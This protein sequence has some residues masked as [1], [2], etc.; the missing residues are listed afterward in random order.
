MARPRLLVM[1]AD[2]LHSHRE[3]SASSTSVS[4]GC[5]S[6]TASDSMAIRWNSLATG[7]STSSSLEIAQVRPF[8]PLIG[9][10]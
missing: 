2:V 4:P 3:T 1:H 10:H 6:S 5:D 9:L 8:R 7:S